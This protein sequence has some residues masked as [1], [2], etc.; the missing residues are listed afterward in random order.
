M[1]AAFMR[2]MPVLVL[3]DHIF[4]YHPIHTPNTVSMQK[5]YPNVK[6][7][8][9]G[10]P[11][12][13]GIHIQI[14]RAYY[15]FRVWIFERKSTEIQNINSKYQ[16]KHKLYWNEWK[17]SIK[18]FFHHRFFRFLI[19]FDLI[20]SILVISLWMGID[21][22]TCNLKHFHCVH[23]FLWDRVAERF[24]CVFFFIIFSKIL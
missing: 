20:M 5:W 14:E 17:K 11:T 6:C 15:L 7:K 4:P 13:M 10:G 16:F 19:H 3:H 21:V 23:S 12:R 1:F 24:G 9:C 22:L 8:E 2:Y 18:V